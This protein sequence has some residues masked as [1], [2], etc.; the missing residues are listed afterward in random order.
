[1]KAQSEVLASRRIVLGV[2]VAMVALAKAVPFAVA[3]P[4]PPDAAAPPASLS[5][6][7]TGTAPAS[8]P[9]DTPVRQ[10]VPS[11][12]CVEHVPAGKAR[13]T[14]T[15]SFP[16]RGLSGHA[17]RL[18]LTVIHGKGERV[19]AD[20]F[21]LQ[22]DSTGA[23][24]LRSAG[25]EFPTAGS[26]AAPRVTRVERDSDAATTVDIVVIPLPKT[27]GRQELVL[28]PLPV[29][30][31]RASGEVMTLCSSV[32]SITVEDPTANHPNAT[33]K[34]NPS[35][36]RQRELWVTMRNLAYGTLIGL[37]VALL[38]AL[39]VAW[40]RRRPKALPPPPPPRPPWE[41]ALEALHDIRH[42]DLVRQG[43]L[44]TH[45]ERVNHV[46]REYL[47]GRYGFDGL[48]STTEEVLSALRHSPLPPSLLAQTERMLRESD[49]VK[50]ADAT[51]SETQCVEALDGTEALVRST[52]RDERRPV[53][54]PL[55]N[56]AQPSASPPATAPVVE[57]HSAP[58]RG[59]EPKE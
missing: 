53:E 44:T 5:L 40:W 35:P 32:H 2:C 47:G 42:A 38:L 54:Q 7:A 3:A 16:K 48:E 56:S 59:E 8:P 17:A 13:P 29:A 23:R 20:A 55:T 27:V 22:R 34:A 21:D 58:G 6:S 52:M 45:L 28:P 51:P 31:A 30:M 4:V 11:N 41:T 14:M 43:R 36:L 50:F 33:P 25:F 24:A 46:L 12:T 19:L 1:M 15:E 26:P 37:G 57:P 9:P 18:S 49:L 39:L 10:A